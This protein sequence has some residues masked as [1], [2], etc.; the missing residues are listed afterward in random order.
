MAQHDGMIN[1]NRNDQHVDLGGDFVHDDLDWH[2]RLDTVP[3]SI[4]T[5]VIFHYNNFISHKNI[6]I[7]LKNLP[8]ILPYHLHTIKKVLPVGISLFANFSSDSPAKSPPPKLSRVLR[9]RRPKQG[10]Q[11]VQFCLPLPSLLVDA[12]TQPPPE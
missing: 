9:Y 10:P 3:K 2:A 8:L 5:T 12:L 6:A 4:K 7:V 1:L 11:Q